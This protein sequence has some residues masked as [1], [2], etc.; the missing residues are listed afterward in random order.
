MG[1]LRS[2]FFQGLAHIYNYVTLHIVKMV[3][4]Y[5][6]VGESAS[7]IAESI[8]RGIDSGALPPD[9]TLPTI[10]GLAAELGVSPTTVN[11]AYA[12]LRSHGRIGGNRRG[13]SRVVPR[14]AYPTAAAPAI[15]SGIRDLVIANPDPEL[16]PPMRPYIERTIK[17]GHLY[18]AELV[19]PQLLAI[20]KKRFT[21]DGIDA[22]HL[23]VVSGALD[24]VER[25]LLTHVVP[26]DMV[27]LE[28]P[29][30]PPYRELCS[31]LG[32]R[33]FPVRTDAFG[34]VPSA[35]AKA[36]RAGAKALVV[37]PR[38]QNPTGAG[39]DA[40]RVGDLVAV[41]RAAKSMIVIEDDYLGF[42]FSNPLTSLAGKVPR[43]LYVRSVGKALGPDL[44]VGIAAADV[45][46]I[47][48]LENRLRLSA[49]WVSWMLQGT[50][51]AMLAD[52]AVQRRLKSAGKMYWSRR[53]GLASQL[54]KRGIETWDGEGF[55]VWVPVNDELAV[56]RF[57]DAAG[58]AVDAGTRYRFE[59]GPGIRVVTT[60][61]NAEEAER[62]A[63]AVADALKSGP[64]STP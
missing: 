23:A 55:A 18:G 4:Q 11:A 8:E 32:L 14:A 52:A 31:V 44:R 47:A 50:T 37:V 6:I 30:Y 22:T 33:V 19:H 61:M 20:A 3:T 48:R 43:W 51:A 60:T 41:L 17:E 40:K 35:L 59:T 63:S 24:A 29:T 13:G 26:G 34:I 12:Q 54:R 21:E 36:V 38:A 16:L 27:A 28:D 42:L 49:G 62:F 58:W 25:A 15:T 57:L 56:V 46:T 2:R 5:Q 39:F 45:L 1:P 9:E 10:R 64:R 7:A 53:N